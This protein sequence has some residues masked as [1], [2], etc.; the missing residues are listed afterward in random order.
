MKPPL[1]LAQTAHVLLATLSRVGLILRALK[2]R[3]DVEEVER[4]EDHA[5]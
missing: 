1:L 3:S 4:E 5:S 2:L